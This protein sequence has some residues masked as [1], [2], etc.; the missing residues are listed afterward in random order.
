[1]TELALG[2]KLNAGQR[3]YLGTVRD[4]AE[5]LLAL[6]NDILDFSKI[7]ARKLELDHVELDLRAT[8]EDTLKSLA[9]RA[10]QKGLELACH[11]RPKVPEGLVGDPNRL[12]RIIVNLVGNAIKFTEQGEIVLRVEPESMSENG[13]FLHFSVSDSG[14]G[15]P[16]EKLAHIFQVFVQA[17]SS[18]TRKYGGT[19]RSRDDWKLRAERV[20]TPKPARFAS[21]WRKQSQFWW[22]RSVRSAHAR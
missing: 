2:T 16:E 1:M 12:R 14:I 8:L 21:N 22:K 10:E 11:I 19:W 13:V 4:S 3:E 17:D 9:V 18:T 20:T 15:I 6:I 5:S 7:E